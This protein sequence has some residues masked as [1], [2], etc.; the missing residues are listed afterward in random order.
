MKR[1]ILHQI[2]EKNPPYQH[3]T[4]KTIKTKWEQLRNI[5]VQS[6]CVYTW[7]CMSVCVCVYLSLC[8]HQGFV[9]H[10]ITVLWEGRE[11]CEKEKKDVR[12]CCSQLSQTLNCCLLLTDSLSCQIYWSH[13]CISPESRMGAT[14][15]LHHL[16]QPLEDPSVLIPLSPP[17]A[18][19]NNWNLCRNDQTYQLWCFSHISSGLK[20]QKMQSCQVNYSLR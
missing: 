8:C 10:L 19:Q 7:V 3:R 4:V 12:K 11:A 9:M 14:R 17:S 20:K 13:R 5:T 6:Q 15:A 2:S 18:C 16:Q 1:D